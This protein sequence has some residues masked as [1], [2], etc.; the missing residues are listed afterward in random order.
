MDYNCI[1]IKI[2]SEYYAIPYSEIIDAMEYTKFFDLLESIKGTNSNA[3]IQEKLNI[4]S[5]SNSL[6]D[7]DE[8]MKKYIII[9]KSTNCYFG[10]ITDYIQN[11][12]VQVAEEY[13]NTDNISIINID[14]RPVKVINSHTINRMICSEVESIQII[15]NLD[16]NKDNL[17]NLI[18]YSRT[19]E[20]YKHSL[21]EAQDEINKLTKEFLEKANKVLEFY[22]RINH[23]YY[24]E[25][26]I[27]IIL[28]D[29]MDVIL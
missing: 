11:T 1:I 19:E 24:E 16:I 12:Q 5:L 23:G 14:S 26:D 10:I 13:F 20:S 18:K 6:F 28:D 8:L 25:K 7:L 9:I 2:C 15:N 29:F 27:K 17:M 22:E 21:D 4:I 3:N